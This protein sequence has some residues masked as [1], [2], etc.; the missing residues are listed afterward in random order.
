MIP[1]QMDGMLCL[2]FQE[3]DTGTDV[4]ALQK[5]QQQKDQQAAAGAGGAK[6]KKVT[7]AQLRVQKGAKYI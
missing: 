5:Q 1:E 6:K 2:P 7:A 4:M 3:W